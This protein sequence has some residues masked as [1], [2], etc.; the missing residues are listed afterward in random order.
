MSEKYVIDA[1][2]WIEYLIRSKT[3]EKVKSVLEKE[4]NEIYTCAATVAE[5][6]SKRALSSYD[7]MKDSLLCTSSNDCQ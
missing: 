6:V 5:V 4:T 1:Y 2:A 7:K 3:G